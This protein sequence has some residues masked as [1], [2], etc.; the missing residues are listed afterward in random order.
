M[1]VNLMNPSHVDSVF[2]AGKVKKWRGN[3]V[4]VD[5]SRVLRLVQD[6]RDAVVRRAGFRTNVLG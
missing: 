4:G 6:A 3:L 2:I 5:V 1:V